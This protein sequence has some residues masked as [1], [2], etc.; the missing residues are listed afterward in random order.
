MPREREAV[1]RR[2]LPPRGATPFC[3]FLPSPP[4]GAGG[5]RPLSPLS[6][7][8]MMSNGSRFKVDGALSATDAVGAGNEPSS[9]GTLLS[10]AADAGSLPVDTR[11]QDDVVAQ[12]SLEWI[13]NKGVVHIMVDGLKCC[14][15]KPP[16]IY[17]A[18]GRGGQ[19]V[20]FGALCRRGCEAHFARRYGGCGDLLAD[21]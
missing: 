8:C 20:D 1:G 4:R 15:R 21:A 14:T 9:S 3:C 12:Q 5:K 17:E 16:G 13:A 7:V 19:W 11:V 18:A 2:F 10:Q 6:S